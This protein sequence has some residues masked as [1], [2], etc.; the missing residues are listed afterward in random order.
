MEEGM[1]TAPTER[2]GDVLPGDHPAVE[3]AAEAGD[4]IAHIPGRGQSR[5]RGGARQPR[6]TRHST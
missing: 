4:C 5:R 2:R 3:L 1:D 6:A